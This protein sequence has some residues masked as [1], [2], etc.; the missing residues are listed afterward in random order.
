[1]AVFIFA[2]LSWIVSAHKW[3]IGPVKTINDEVLSGYGDD[4]QA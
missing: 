3:F 4:K 2:S 1:M